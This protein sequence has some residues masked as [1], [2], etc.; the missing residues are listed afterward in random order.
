MRRQTSPGVRSSNHSRNTLSIQMT[1]P[2]IKG[3]EMKTR[4]KV[5][6]PTTVAN[7]DPSVFDDP[8]AV[9][10]DRKVNA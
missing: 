3:I 9:D 8:A 6:L 5:V 2:H 1:T 7:R 10:F 4:E